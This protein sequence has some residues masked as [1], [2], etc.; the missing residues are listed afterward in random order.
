[1]SLHIRRS[2]A[3][4]VKLLLLPILLATA[5]PL[6]A[7]GNPHADL[8][9]K[10]DSV[11]TVR[12]LL[13]VQMPGV[14]REVDNETDCLLISAD[15]LVLCSHTNLG[16]YIGVMARI[17]GRSEAP[18]S[19]QPREVKVVIGDASGDGLPAKVVA[20]DSDRDLAWLLIDEPPADLPYLDLAAGAEVAIGDRAYQLRRLD[21]YF[22]R[23]PLISEMVIG[24][25][26]DKPRRLL[27]P[28]RPLEGWLGTPVF[29]AEGRLVGITVVQ[30]PADGEAG[31]MMSNARSLP[32]QASTLDDM[33]GGVI[34]PAA[35]IARATALAREV[36]AADQAEALE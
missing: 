16:G 15:G 36:Y 26:L 29:T 8:R 1:M 33:I 17:V 30:M 24:A 23:E 12:Y 5:L 21:K 14:D 6:A 28:S 9:S 31:S 34:L 32:G 13:K 35:D 7:A 18:I 25:V 19:S 27:V 3:V 4:T 2:C 22:G 20:R 11:V 10:V